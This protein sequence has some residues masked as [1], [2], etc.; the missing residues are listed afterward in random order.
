MPRKY[1]PKVKASIYSAARKLAWA[2]PTI[3]KETI[4]KAMVLAA[5]TSLIKDEYFSTISRCGCPD[6][7][8]RK[9]SCK[10]QIALWLKKEADIK[11]MQEFI[12]AV[13]ND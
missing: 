9:R 4:A 10:H 8:H 13:A 3:S 1:K 12:G 7:I 5:D 11:E 6:H 2:R